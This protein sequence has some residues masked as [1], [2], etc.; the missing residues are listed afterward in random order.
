MVVIVNGKEY[1]ALQLGTV[2]THP[3]YRHQ[4]LAAKL[5]NYILNKYGNEYDFTYL[6]AN[7]KVLNFYPKFG[8][9]RVQESS[10]KVKASDLKKQVTPKS[11][12]RKLDV[13]IQANLEGI[14]HHLIS[15]ETKMIHF[16]FM[17]ERDYENIQSEPRTESDDILFV[18]PNLIE[19][20][21]EILFPLTAHA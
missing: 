6:F 12:L 20:E 21:K 16:S 18:R 15:D 13:N 4:G 9:E 3:A 7:D 14:V 1:Q 8:F 10:F 5:I 11:T 19:R 2:M 17:P